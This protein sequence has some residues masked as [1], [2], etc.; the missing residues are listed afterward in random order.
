MRY[1]LFLLLILPV[2]SCNRPP[3]CL[4]AALRMAGRNRPELEAVL[5]HYSRHP[6]DSLKYR[7]AVFLIENMPYHHTERDPMIEAFRAYL[8]ET[9]VEEFAWAN[10]LNIYRP[11]SMSIEKEQD[12]LHVTAEFLIRNIDFS[13]KVWQEATLGQYVSFDSFCENILPYRLA[14]EPLEYWKETYYAAF[15]PVIDTMQHNN[16]LDEVCMNL[17][18]ELKKQ[19]WV[20]GVDLQSGGFGADALLRTRYGACKEQAELVAYMLRSVGIPSGIDLMIQHPNHLNQRHYWNYA[21]TLDG[22][23]FGFDMEGNTVADGRWKTRKYGKA[24]RQSFALQKESLSLRYKKKYIPEGGL[25][26]KLLRDVS[27]VYCP[28]T[29]VA[30]RVNELNRLGRK[31]LVYLCVFNNREWIPMA[32]SKP[33]KGIAGFKH[34]EPDILF[35]VRLIDGKRNVAVTPPFIFHGNENIQFLDADTGRLQTMT[36]LRKYRLP[37]VLPW[38]HQRSEGGMFQGADTPDFLDSVTLHKIPSPSGFNWMNVRIDDPREYRYVR[39]LSA[40]TGAFNN[41]AEVEF[42]SDGIKL[43]GE[44]IGTDSSAMAF[45]N[46]TKYAVFDG[47]PL[48]FFDALYPNIAWAGLRLEKPCRIDAIRYLFRNDDNGV[49]K[50]DGYELLYSK[51]GEWLSFGKQVADTSLLFYGNVPSNTLYWL[52]NHTRGREERP[53]IYEDGKQVFY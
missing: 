28:D 30:V 42:Y 3:D 40:Q 53:F 11:F 35:Q 18:G 46:D 50:G 44:V 48:T 27:F 24:Y 22:S 1:I 13:F 16:R 41:M 29:H 39:Y 2:F 36:L 25:R 32:W 26:E 12:V 34:V 19:A 20:W 52:R 14:N 10:F 49:R 21:Y 7:A 47:D 43:T 23:L 17:V 15:Q 33:K 37:P 6:A 5:H 45:P 4:E 31:D 9:G 38:Y 8:D 51:K